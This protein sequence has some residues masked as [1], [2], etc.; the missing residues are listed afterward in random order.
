M[1]DCYWI[2]GIESYDYD[3]GSKSIPILYNGQL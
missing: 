1:S 3:E 2:L